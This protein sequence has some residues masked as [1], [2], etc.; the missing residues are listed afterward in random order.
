MTVNNNWI[1]IF[2]LLMPHSLGL[3][4]IRCFIGYIT[5]SLWQQK[6]EH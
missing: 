6:N 4:P 2:I 1:R 5:F 3:S